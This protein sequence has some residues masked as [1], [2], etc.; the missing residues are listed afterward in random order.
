VVEGALSPRDGAALIVG[1]LADITPY[2]PHRGRFVGDTFGVARLVGLHYALDEAP[3]DDEDTCR[4]LEDDIVST[5]GRIAR[6]EEANDWSDIPT[7]SNGT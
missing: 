4:R 3:E 5:C 1:L 7:R 2:L 6:G